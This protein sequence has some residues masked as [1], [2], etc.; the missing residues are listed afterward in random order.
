MKLGP[1]FDCW[2]RRGRGEPKRT[3]NTK[4]TIEVLKAP[5]LS[6]LSTKTCSPG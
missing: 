1:L 3:P 5:N 6:S 2:W 4:V